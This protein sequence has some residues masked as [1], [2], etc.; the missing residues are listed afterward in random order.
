MLVV[1]QGC[2]ARHGAS[3]SVIGDDVNA[4]GHSIILSLSMLRFHCVVLYVSEAQ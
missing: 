4:A 2:D 3:V 1:A